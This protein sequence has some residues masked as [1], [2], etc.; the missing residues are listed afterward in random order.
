LRKLRRQ[1]RHIFGSQHAIDANGVRHAENGN[2]C[3]QRKKFLRIDAQFH[4][5]LAN[6]SDASPISKENGNR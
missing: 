3:R 5:R 4:G 6:I 2:Q 1:R